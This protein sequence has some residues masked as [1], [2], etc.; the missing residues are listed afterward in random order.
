MHQPASDDRVDNGCAVRSRVVSS[1]QRSV[2]VKKTIKIYK[3]TLRLSSST[4]RVCRSRLSLMLI[5]LTSLF[6]LRQLKTGVRTTDALFFFARFA[7]RRCVARHSLTPHARLFFSQ[8]LFSM[9]HTVT[10]MYPMG[11]SH[12]SVRG[13]GIFAF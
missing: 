3:R 11:V 12:E 8:C 10:H 2:N 7:V 13:D 9:Q 1:L 4:H 6:P 5:P